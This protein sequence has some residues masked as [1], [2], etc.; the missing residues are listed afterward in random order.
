M[1]NENPHLLIYM[2]G[3]KAKYLVSIVD[4]I[5]HGETKIF[6]DDL[7]EF[8]NIAEDLQLKGVSGESS[9]REEHKYIERTSSS[10]PQVL[11]M[12]KIL[13]LDT[14]A[15]TLHDT[16]NKEDS[17]E[18]LYTNVKVELEDSITNNDEKVVTIAESEDN[19]VL[20]QQILSMMEKTNSEWKC[21][22]CGKISK[23]SH[24]KDHIEAIHIEAGPH[25]CKYCGKLYKTRDSLRRHH[26]DIRDIHK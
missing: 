15:K 26:C 17:S 10:S 22:V 14:G 25:P 9:L 4:F 3:I 6:Q 2:R 12:E 13:R 24:I 1:E 23:K 18:K 20:D 16:I 8:L 7:D 5:Y 19:T 21:N 11:S